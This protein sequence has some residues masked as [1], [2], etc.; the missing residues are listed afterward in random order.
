MRSSTVPPAPSPAERAITSD[1]NHSHTRTT[2]DEVVVSSPGVV[3]SAEAEASPVG[4]VLPALPKWLRASRSSFVSL[5]SVHVADPNV[6]V[7]LRDPSRASRVLPRRE[8]T[9]AASQS[10]SDTQ[11]C[12]RMRMP[13]GSASTRTSWPL[14]AAP[15]SWLMAVVCRPRR[16]GLPY[17]P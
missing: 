1:V 4:R 13:S 15:V 12:A 16:G 3:P 2:L 5:R 14:L 8:E 11:T 17:Q 9:E 10:S 7:S 6:P